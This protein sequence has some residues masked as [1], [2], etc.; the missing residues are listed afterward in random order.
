MNRLLTFVM[1]GPLL[2]GCDLHTV[3]FVSDPVPAAP[4]ALSSITADGAVY[5]AWEDG[6][7][8]ASDHYRIYR[9]QGS[10]ERLDFL[11]ATPE[12]GYVDF[13]VQNGVT[14][15]YGVS[16]VSPDGR[17][18]PLSHVVG[19]TPRP[20]GYD[21]VLFDAGTRPDR[22]AFDFA[23]PARVSVDDASGDVFLECDPASG[24]LTL[25]AFWG[26]DIQDMGFTESLDDI[27]YSPT[28]G[29]IPDGA[30]VLV[31]GHTYVVWTEDNH[32]A[33]LRAVEV[34]T[35]WA[36]LDWAYQVDPGN[37][38]LVKPAHD[39]GYGRRLHALQPLDKTQA[40]IRVTPAL[41]TTLPAGT[42]GA[43]R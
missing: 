22:A 41:D 18:G 20:E 26:T 1:L 10:P 3:V 19:D 37:P 13:A 38:E 39:S 2:S 28:D 15:F 4:A 42:R 14:Y 31:A 30:A 35:T 32:F 40:A 29:W 9:G 34:A 16:A 43:R 25:V 11:A 21:L 6:S 7:A 12:L 36:R 27:S 17:E 5:L 33:K 23:R 24:L 8:F